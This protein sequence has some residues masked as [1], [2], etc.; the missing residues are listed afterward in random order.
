MD[1]PLDDEVRELLEARRGDWMLIAKELDISHSWISQF[2][3]GLIP[4]P[5][6]PRLRDLKAH[7]ATKAATAT[8]G[9]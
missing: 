2:V 4:N 1:K 5:G 8:A 9:S 7:L 3:R 6:Y